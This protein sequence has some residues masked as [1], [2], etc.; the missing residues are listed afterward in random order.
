MFLLWF[1]AKLAVGLL[2]GEYSKPPP[3]AAESSGADA[4]ATAA[5]AAP[6]VPEQQ[7][8]IA[9]GMFKRLVGR[10]HPEFSTSKQQ[11]F[12]SVFLSLLSI[13]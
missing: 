9:P 4:A 10:G 5:D 3:A 11:V 12:F 2:S 8:G 6:S 13:F 7:E 1:R